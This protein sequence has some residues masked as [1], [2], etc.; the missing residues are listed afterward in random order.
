MLA[1]LA[2]SLS[3]PAALLA[4]SEDPGGEAFLAIAI[5]AV[6]S[7]SLFGTTARMRAWAPVTGRWLSGLAVLGG[8]IG[9]L[10][11]L[12]GGKNDVFDAIG[13]GLIAGLLTI[14]GLCLIV[15]P[16][17]FLWL[18]ILGPMFGLGRRWQG[19]AA[20]AA[21][22]RR[23]ERERRREQERYERAAPERERQERERAG[24]QRRRAEARAE[25]EVYFSLHAPEIAGRFPKAEFAEFMTRHLGDEHS[26]EYVERR[27][28]QLLALM[29]KHLERVKSPIEL[30][31]LDEILAAF[32]DRIRR[33]RESAL[34]EK[35]KEVILVDLEQERE[36]A[37]RKALREGRL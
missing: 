35:D 32:D 16:A 19:R 11:A 24:A 34:H 26:P 12:R 13:V 5:L 30:K 20:D 9:G 22:R 27:A 25:C 37:V 10:V 33:V 14:L 6:L 17:F 29:R 1:L 18:H 3:A 31:S 7:G 4:A 21:A 36:E 28:E 2:T 23:T 8:V 15:P